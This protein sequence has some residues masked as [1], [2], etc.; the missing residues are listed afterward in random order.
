MVGKALALAKVDPR[1]RGGD[2]G[3]M[4]VETLA[5]GRSPHAR[6]RR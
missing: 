5:V 6:G 2:V 4:L 1:M 3:S